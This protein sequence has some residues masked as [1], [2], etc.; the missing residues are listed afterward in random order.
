MGKK[1]HIFWMCACCF[2]HP[3]CKAHAPY[4]I[5][6]LG[7]S[8]CGIFLHITSQTAVFSCWWWGGANRLLNTKCVFW[9]SLQLLSEAFLILRRIQRDCF[10]NLKTSLCKVAGIL[11]RF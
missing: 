6:V 9:F 11:V 3:A 1:C 10:V 5:A 8:G 2:R 7:M 4:F